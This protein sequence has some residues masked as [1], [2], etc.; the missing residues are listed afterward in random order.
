MLSIRSIFYSFA[1]APLLLAAAA[2]VCTAQTAKQKKAPL[3]QKAAPV[4]ESEKLRQRYIEATRE[5]KA[6]LERLGAL[7]EKDVMK[8]NERLDKSKQLFADGLIS[9]N[10][11]TDSEKAVA[12]AELKV[13]EVKQQMKT[14]DMQVAQTLIEIESEKQMAKLGRIGRGRVLSTA[15]FIR[16]DGA[17]PWALSQFGKIEQFFQLT[18]KRA[19]PIAVFG[20]GAIH[21]Q[22]R[23]DHRNAMD[24]SLN[25]NGAE[26]QALINFL[27]TNGI[28]FSA[29]R[30][31]IPG[32][33]TGPHIH[34]GRPSHRY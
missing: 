21:N 27:Q 15:A 8:A 17:G 29:F 26:G 31:A 13:A 30:T 20:Q 9:K 5:Y 32:V 16:Y 11:L 6:S 4:S 2:D 7:Y 1:M 22:W 25:P 33:A 3:K 23:L 28:P 12:A 10:Q 14:A 34:I 18:F 19:L 24:V